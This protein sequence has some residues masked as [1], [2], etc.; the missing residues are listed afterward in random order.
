MIYLKMEYIPKK[1]KKK[2]KL[3][4]ISVTTKDP[5]IEDDD[6]HEQ[7][8]L[9][10]KTCSMDKFEKLKSDLDA[11]RLKTINVDGFQENHSRKNRRCLYFQA[12]YN[13]LLKSIDL[14]YLYSK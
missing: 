13:I 8:D 10:A 2:A 3:A 5:G 6:E 4:V 14:Y 7:L 11:K 12:I 9:I 1:A